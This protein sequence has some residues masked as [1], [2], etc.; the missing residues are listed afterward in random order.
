MT[1][2]EWRFRYLVRESVAN[3]LSGGWRTVSLLVIL[4]SVV[5]AAAL[6]EAFSVSSILNRDVSLIQRGRYVLRISPGVDSPSGIDA[7]ACARVAGQGG[8][9]SSGAVLRSGLYEVSSTPGVRVRRISVTPGLLETLDL[10]GPGSAV[11]VGAELADELDVIE[12]SAIRLVVAGSTE[13]LVVDE[14]MAHPSVRFPEAN[15]AVLVTGAPLGEAA[16]CYVEAQPPVFDEYRTGIVALESLAAA[17]PTVSGLVSVEQGETPGDRYARRP[18]RF[19][20]YAAAAVLCS[21]VAVSLQVRR[22][23]IGVYRASGSSRPAVFVVLCSEYLILI[24]LAVA[25]AADV[26][27]IVT[28]EAGMYAESIRHGLSVLVTTGVL[29]AAG[30]AVVAW[31]ISLRMDVP[32]ALKDR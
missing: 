12:G 14:V 3:L 31:A 15:R 4:M 11:I 18:S 27:V 6:F 16:D 17:P 10:A 26:L 20:S 23:E 19:A 13:T 5:A 9:L 28:A 21:L 30:T 24:A 7:G 22:S 1:V 25:M 2:R 8:V 29:T 32:R